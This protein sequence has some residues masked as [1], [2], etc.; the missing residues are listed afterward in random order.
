MYYS[1]GVSVRSHQGF[2]SMSA[3]YPPG[4][5]SWRHSVFLDVFL[6]MHELIEAYLI[7]YLLSR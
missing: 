3:S 4:Q 1:S 5:S 7:F 6:P 2:H